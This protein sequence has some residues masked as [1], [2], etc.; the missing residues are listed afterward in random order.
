MVVEAGREVVAEEA[1]FTERDVGPKSGLAGRGKVGTDGGR[2]VVARAEPIPIVLGGGTAKV[3]TEGTR[4]VV[5]RAEPIPIVL[6]G[7]TGLGKGITSISMVLSS[8][9]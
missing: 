2:E 4:D 8:T 7:G 1:G 3:G 6:G 5:E 9:R